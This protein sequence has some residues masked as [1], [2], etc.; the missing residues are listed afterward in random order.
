MIKGL[1]KSGIYRGNFVLKIVNI[2]KQ[3]ILENRVPP[4]GD[5]PG[6]AKRKNEVPAGLDS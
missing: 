5:L 3:V 6:A 1:I 4:P 2:I